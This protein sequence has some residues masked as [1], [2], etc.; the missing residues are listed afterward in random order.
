MFASMDPHRLEVA[1]EAKTT[2]QVFY[3]IG[4]TSVFHSTKSVQY[5][6]IDIVGL[7]CS[8]I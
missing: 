3:H 2:T 7:D 6:G 4:K 8:T 1:V 5:S